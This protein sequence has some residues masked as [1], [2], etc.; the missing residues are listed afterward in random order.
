[1]NSMENKKCSIKTVKTFQYFRFTFHNLNVKAIRVNYFYANFS[2]KSQEL[3]VK[4][5]LCMFHEE[6][7]VYFGTADV[8]ETFW[9]WQLIYVASG[10]KSL[11]PQGEV[12]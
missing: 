2:F 6:T 1:M 9:C 8:T 11:I 3:H 12:A 10:L 4:P 5:S 7:Y